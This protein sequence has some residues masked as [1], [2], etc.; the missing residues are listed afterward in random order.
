[1]PM[2]AGLLRF[3][4][5]D[6]P[7]YRCSQGIL[8][9]RE[10]TAAARRLAALLLREVP[11]GVPVG[12][13]GH[14]EPLMPVCIAACAIANR[15]YLP[16][17]RQIP[18]ARAERMLQ[19]AGAGLLLAAGEGF[20][21]SSAAAV[22][23]A[24]LAETAFDPDKEQAA[25]AAACPGDRFY[26]LFT[27]GSSGEPKGVAVTRGNAA[28]FLRWERSL[29][30]T[31]AG[32]VLSHAAY[33]F[34]LSVA[35]LWLALTSGRCAAVLESE[36]FGDYPALFGRIGEAA[37]SLAVLTPS[38]AELLLASPSFAAERF[39]ALRE[40]LFCGEP[41]RAGTVRR[42][43]ARF[44]GIRIVNSYGPTECTVAVTGC[45]MEEW[46]AESGEL[47]VGRSKP[48][49]QIIVRDPSTG[50]AL[51]D[52]TA[53]ELGVSGDSVTPGYLGPA[54][55][56]FCTLDGVFSYRTG[57]LGLCRDGLFYCLG[58]LDRQIKWHGLR[59]EPGEI[60]QT[61]LRCRGIAQAAVLPVLRGGRVRRLRAFV[62][63]SGGVFLNPAALE[64]TLRGILPAGMVPS[65]EVLPRMPLTPNGK[66]DYAALKELP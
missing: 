6:A 52:G 30:S 49:T 59:I 50:R 39:P 22:G 11:P 38:F 57:D 15:P 19:A 5:S 14:K 63:P 47:P 36:L 21:P 20:V 34:D 25:P 29:L 27:S 2:T 32:P 9:F 17:D 35:G 10:L 48:G 45:E 43:W 23:P 62:S 44:P 8:S 51:P 58:R 24:A 66:C 65:V 18:P 13:Y 37:P 16:I 31:A 7:A 64:E 40:L 61:L 55:G 41:L 56:G 42:L 3:S 33:S 53:G 4:E 60:E 1:M 28:S 54:Q 26:L 12:I 46:M